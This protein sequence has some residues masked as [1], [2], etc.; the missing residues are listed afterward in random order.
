MKRVEVGRG[1]EPHADIASRVEASLSTF[2]KR[3]KK[4]KDQFSFI[5]FLSSVVL[6]NTKG[7]GEESARERGRCDKMEYWHI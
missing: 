1:R 6:E 7:E 5:W 3:E 4:I 2:R